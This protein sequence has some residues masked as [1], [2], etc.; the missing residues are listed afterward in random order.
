MRRKHAKSASAGTRS[1]PAVVVGATSV[2]SLLNYAFSLVLLWILPV[3]D[4]AVVASVTALLLVFGTVA[5]ASAPWVLAREVAL[6]TLDPLRRSRAIAFAGLV[7]LGQAASAALI[8]ALII[9][10]YADWQTTVTACVAVGLIFF[11]TAAAG[12]LQ[13]TERFTLLYLL[14]VGEVLVKVAVGV[15]LVKAGTGPWGAVAG[16]VFGAVL[17]LLGGIY[18]MRADALRAWKSRHASWMLGVFHDRELWKSSAGIIG[19]QAG[20]AVIAGLDSIV[21]SIM[22]ARRPELATYQVVQILGRIPFYIASAFA[23]IVFPRMARLRESRTQAVNSSL[24]ALLRV[25]AAVAIVVGTAPLP[26]LAHILPSRYGAYSLLLPWAATTGFSLGGINLITTYWQATG[27]TRRA[28]WTLLAACLV[29]VIADTLA[30]W[31]GSVLHLA[32][33]AAITSATALLS[34]LF[35]VRS[36]WPGALRGVA[37]QSALVLIP[38][39]F[40]FFLRGHVLAWLAVAVLG[41]GLPALRSLYLYGLA[42]ASQGHP[43]LLHLA[44]EDPRR[45]GAG[46]GSLRTAEVDRRL[47]RDFA[48]TVVCARYPGSRP[49]TDDGVRYVHIGLPRGDQLSLLSYF[50]CL[51]WALLRYPGEL[52]IEDFAAPF[53]SIA[54]PWL[55]SR[56]VTGIVQWLFAKEKAHQY[57]LPFHWVERIGLASH[58]NL[59]AVSEDL[60]GELRRRNPRATILALENGLPDEAFQ[61]RESVRNNILFLGRLEIAQKGLDI[62]LEA[63]A[64]ISDTMRKELIIAGVG[65]DKAKLQSLARTLGIGERVVFAGHIPPCDRFEFLASAELVAMPSRYETYGLVASEALA[66]GTPVVAFDIP[67]LR[68]V[69]AGAGGVLVPPFDTAAY[70][71]ALSNTLRD[72]ELRTRLGRAGRESVGHL[73]WDDVAKKQG[74][75]LSHLL[76]PEMERDGAA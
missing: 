51:P 24:H 48:V 27:R 6:S 32:W 23:V 18:Y 2:V 11:S 35:L 30:V 4:Y 5:G 61:P 64:S 68:T 17:V 15:S 14:R 75:F 50:F 38:G 59:V 26:I 60:A 66:V 3:R 62:L 52:V 73:R 34:L 29:A 1:A 71:A 44:F 33:S 13:G 70:A 46:G 7:A 74:D 21:A 41:L 16:F 54:V 9:S 67:C 57:G 63:F 39:T 10:R 20:T 76:I 56:P 49:R 69:V 55:T 72:S 37:R 12:Y 43:R 58:H 28:G 31:D 45:P 36:D 25:C 19:I 53:S 42:L 22:L 40:L 8:S 47:S 65:P